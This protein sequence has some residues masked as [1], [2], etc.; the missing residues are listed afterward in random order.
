[1]S[2]LRFSVQIQATADWAENQFDES[3]EAF[4]AGLTC[5]DHTLPEATCTDEPLSPTQHLAE[6]LA[7]RA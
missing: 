2:A 1:M 4:E 7:H 5:S 6:T 3:G